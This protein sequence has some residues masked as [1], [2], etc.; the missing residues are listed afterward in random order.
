MNRT[1]ERCI[2]SRKHGYGCEAL[3]EE[4]DGCL[5]GT[6]PFYKT[7]YQQKTQEEVARNRC[8][9]LGYTFRTRDEVVNEMNY[10][11]SYD[12]K[13]KKKQ[14]QKDKGVLQFNTLDNEYIEYDSIGS[15]SKI[16]GI[17]IEK[18]TLLIRKQEEY[19]GYKFMM[20]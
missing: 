9:E 20:L 4:D 3:V 19:K 14:K 15:A 5:D 1:N 13:Y 17:P 2:C 6:C 12:K 18:L 8:E 16:L 10:R 7:E 11:S